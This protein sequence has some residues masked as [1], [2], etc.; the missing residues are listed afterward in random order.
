M[1]MSSAFSFIFMQIKVIFIRIVS[2]L[3]SLCNRGTRELG[4]GLLGISINSKKEDNLVRYTQVF[5]N[6]SWK[7]PFHLTFIPKFPEF[8]VEQFAFRKFNN[9]RIFWNFS[10]ELELFLAIC[11][12]FE[13]FEILGQ[14]VSA[15]DWSESEA[16]AEEPTNHKAQNRTLYC[17]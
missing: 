14:I 9:F 13:N 1:K 8:S 3:D 12:R 11:P 10:Q 17:D 16:E 5:E 4:N 6:F 2:L 7:F 15:L